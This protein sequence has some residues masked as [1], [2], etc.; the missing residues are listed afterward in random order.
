MSEDNDGPAP[1]EDVPDTLTI[2]LRKPVTF[3]GKT[4]TTLHLRE[5]TGGEV[6]EISKRTGYE[7]I[8]FGI[9]KIAS[10]PER[11]VE[12]IGSRDIRAADRYLSSFFV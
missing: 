8:L 6:K 7:A 1:T 4:Y 5:P 11:A 3:E 9:H 2:H 10:I 12:M